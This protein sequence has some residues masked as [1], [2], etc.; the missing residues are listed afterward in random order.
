MK[1]IQRLI[2]GCLVL[3]MLFSML[4]VQVFANSDESELQAAET[5]GGTCGDDLTWEFDADSGTLT[6]SG[7]GD[8]D[9]SWFP[10][11]L[12]MKD[13]NFAPWYDIA[14]N[15]TSVVI[16]DGVT[17]VG[18]FA[19]YGCV[20]LTD[21]SIPDSVTLIS[22][23]FVGCDSLTE[24]YI[25]A[26]VTDF[27]YPSNEG[28]CTGLTRITVDADNPVY[29]SDEAGMLYNKDKTKFIGCPTGY[30]G[31]YTIA[32]GVTEIGAWAFVR[33]EGLTE[34]L[35]P[36]TVTSIG[37][38][39]FAGCSGLSELILPEGITTIASET[40]FGCALTELTIPA[41][42]NSIAPYALS[43]CD[44]LR[45]VYFKGDAPSLQFDSLVS[46]AA[47]CYYPANNT[48]WTE[49]ITDQYGGNIVWI[50]YEEEETCN[51][52]YTAEVTAPTCEEKGYTTFTCDCGDSYVDNYVDALG[53]DYK[54][55]YCTR[56]DEEDPAPAKE[57]TCGNDARWIFDEISGTLTI[58]G[59]GKMWDYDALFDGSAEPVF[60]P[61][62]GFRN[63]IRKVVV[64]EGITHIG[65][66]AFYEISKA[67]EI[68]LPQRG[69]VR[70]GE[71]A[72]KNSRLNQ[73]DLP[74]SVSEIGRSA[75]FGTA[76]TEIV[77][78]SGVTVIE[79]AMFQSADNLEEVTLPDGIKEIKYGAFWGTNLS[80]ITIPDSVTRIGANAFCNCVCLS[81]IE[82][83]EYVESLGTGAFRSCDN[84]EKI[85]FK[86]NAP[87]F[88]AADE[89]GLG[90]YNQFG[91]V[92]ATAYYPANLSTWTEGVM[93]R[94][95]GTITWIPYGEEPETH[96]HSGGK[97]TCAS[98]AIC[99]ECGENYGEKD[100]TNHTGETEI[101]N[102]KEATEF[103]DGYTG[104]T[105]CLSCGKLLEQGKVISG[106]HEHDH[107]KTVTAPTCEEKGYTTYTCKCGDSYVADEVAALG[108]DYDEGVITTK[109]GCKTEGVMTYTCLNNAAHSYAVA[110]AATG[111][112]YNNG[113]VTTAPGC[114]TTGVKTYTCQNDK[115]HIYTTTIPVI[116]HSYDEGVM[117]PAPTCTADG[118]R[119]FTCQNDKTHTKRET[120]NATGHTMG[121][122][123]EFKPS[124][125]KSEGEDR[126]YCKN[127]DCDYYESR[128]IEKLPDP[129][130]KSGTCGENLT[131]Q[132]DSE[133]VLTISGTGPMGNFDYP[134][135]PPW[136]D[137]GDDWTL[138]I[139]SVIINEGVTTVGDYAFEY[140]TE[141]ETVTL[142]DSITSIGIG[143]FGEC[144]NL[145]S[146]NIPNNTTS[147]KTGAFFFCWELEEVYIPPSV[148]NIDSGAFYGGPTKFWVDSENPY[149]SSDRFGVLYNKEQ[150]ELIQCMGIADG[151]FIPDTVKKIG[152]CAFE[153]G[154]AWGHVI[155]PE[156]VE[157]IGNGAF[158]Y[159]YGLEA[160]TIPKSVTTIGS[161]VFVAGDYVLKD[162]Y[163]NGSRSQWN[164][165]K[166]DETND[167]ELLNATIHYSVEEEDNGTVRFFR[168]ITD[169]HTLVFFGE[170]EIS[171]DL[172]HSVTEET[173][174]SF[175]DNLDSLLG[176]YVLAK[177]KVEVISAALYD[178]ILLSIEP[179]ETKTGTVTVFDGETITI[180]GTTYTVPDNLK[181]TPIVVGDTIMYHLYEGEL[182]GFNGEGSYGSGDDEEESN[183]NKSS[184]TVRYYSSWDQTSKTVSFGR[185]VQSMATVADDADASLIDALNS[186]KGSYVFVKTKKQEGKDI[187]VSMVPVQTKFGTVSSVY[188]NSIVVDGTAYAIPDEH[189]LSGISVNDY[190]LFHVY[191]EIVLNVEFL[192][193]QTGELMGWNSVTRDVHI[194]VDDAP[195][196][197]AYSF[198]L[199][200]LANDE[201]LKLL[202]NL[203]GG[204]VTIAKR[205]H[206]FKDTQG[207]IYSIFEYSPV[208]DGNFSYLSSIKIDNKEVVFNYTYHYDES[209]FQKSSYTYQHGLTQMSLRV[210]MSAGD[211]RCASGYE[212]KNGYDNLE[213]LMTD[214]NF[215]K[216][217]FHY[218]PS[219]LEKD[220]DNIGY[221]IGSKTIALED[222]EKCTLIMIGVR[223]SGYGAE[224]GG[225]FHIGESGLVSH[226][227]FQIA[228]DQVISGLETYIEENET[229]FYPRIK[230]WISGFS[231]AGATTNL[232]A[233]FLD[234]GNVNGVSP[235]D[236]YAYCFEC[237]QNTTDS[238]VTEELYKNIVSIVNPIDLVTKLAMSDWNFS[239]YG[240][241]Y[242]LPYM[243][244]NGEDYGSLNARMRKE[245]EKILS[246]Q[247]GV[248]ISVD[249]AYKEVKGQASAFDEFASFLAYM[250]ENREMYTTTYQET[251]M[252]AAAKFLPKAD[253][254][255]EMYDIISS[256]SGLVA[257]LAKEAASIHYTSILE[258]L[259][260]F[261]SMTNDF[262]CLMNAHYMELCLS[263]VD[264]LD[265]W[266]LISDGV[267]YRMVFINCPVDV[268]VYNNG[269]TLVAKIT[270]N[271]VQEIN[272]GIVARID[273]NGQ[274]IVI[275]PP[276][277][278]Y[279]L[280]LNAT[281]NGYMT[282]TV[283]EYNL[284]S[285]NTE[286]VVSYY[287]VELT[288]GDC[289]HGTIENLNESAEAKYPLTLSDGQEATATIDQSGVEV[290][291]FTVDVQV[292][293]DGSVKGGGRYLN[294]EFAKVTAVASEGSQFVGWFVDGKLVSTDAE[295][296]FAVKNDTTITAQFKSADHV[297]HTADTEWLTDSTNHWHKC[298]GCAEIMDL[299][300]HSGGTATCTKQAVCKI[301]G[302]S[303]GKLA[304]HD[305]EKGWN[306]GNEAGHWH[307]CKNCFA[308][309]LPQKHSP[310]AAATEDSAQTCTVCGYVIT[311]ALGHSC[312]PGSHWYYGTNYH[313]KECSCGEQFSMTLHSYTDDADTTCN[314]CGKV[315]EISAV[316]TPETTKP[317]E[318]TIPNPAEEN[319]IAEETTAETTVNT[320]AVEE[321]TVPAVSEDINA[322]ESTE[323]SDGIS[324]IIPAIVLVVSGSLIAL[325]M[326]L[327]KKKVI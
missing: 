109:P 190:I 160:V 57:G 233:A 164:Q 13:P 38:S 157:C 240:I 245:Y 249:T 244:Y 251:I 300:A 205:I 137:I 182:V 113:E 91:G 47:T 193:M 25:P 76:L 324:V 41:S 65:N 8:M 62:F 48:T 321:V 219:N 136:H 290:K 126:R 144:Y 143:A 270:N 318:A 253:V 138:Y 81:E 215:S 51:H 223:G 283:T 7:T 40:F 88:E 103:E 276:H 104:D 325:V 159:C 146:I 297:T 210:A 273:S 151:F 192:P 255:F 282:Y 287:D 180:D 189:I 176:T 227:G 320:E 198:T 59:T 237:P 225:N 186:L 169:D 83:P 222:G 311:P 326:F 175:L 155:I 235:Q 115:S 308:H 106:T 116:G 114:E 293:N 197:G 224:W 54:Y 194:A 127:N 149:Y 229:S 6:I 111:H 248:N 317:T 294:G 267:S 87:V 162:V 37:R 217:K 36:E 167:D 71:G 133:G 304:A 21:V 28:V 277:Q 132:L 161:N 174:K 86:G 29:S 152:D 112:N 80:E 201:T 69:L 238:S 85:T 214:L 261:F 101:R 120:I 163:Y 206:F 3:C 32:E 18:A 178:H 79:K 170:G 2:S 117:N 30:Q 284:D 296:R 11:D 16:E 50:A 24:V 271:V 84:L 64:S 257:T 299:A 70:V 147:I 95:G 72:F 34:I 236:V 310:G 78:P 191:E 31:S 52:S 10:Y 184:S 218:P 207:F 165:I 315:R 60:C 99:S 254:D 49:V 221:G 90:N 43:G 100:S 269:G 66:H 93:Q 142:P 259:L 303:Y 185:D 199:S 168:S 307:E 33:C 288:K 97:A 22:C 134:K 139:S 262:D 322:V 73:I 274:K 171:F 291:T 242:L 63:A 314:V 232:V 266:T 265:D 125:Y 141:L 179:L 67:Y 258:K 119:I 226:L 196:L 316:E 9:S 94:Y 124:T 105:Y 61:W 23:T 289:L 281:D 173:D 241:T 45:E 55:G 280:T 200:N 135:D 77:I 220:Y 278:E 181:D 75:F 246:Y 263:W 203:S 323:S 204:N 252:D 243:E 172:G 327:K 256:I 26:S 250:T 35:I 202:N 213:A 68:D 239:R 150:T 140:C 183:N 12:P 305:Y 121:E 209:W 154:G 129:I 247:N 292:A 228:A 231:R 230:V 298:T 279:T 98:A 82:I 128:N 131:W 17:S 309:T 319:P 158:S 285:T 313:W 177:T 286:R 14:E 234:E 27:R 188:R 211:I 108:H 212:S 301:C 53:H 1:A 92:T 20:N 4:P 195:D 275:L 58:S 187:L 295:Y 148:T 107:E 15:I 118:V 46:L 102:A 42:V 216:L 272:N 208:I 122:W 166:I 110:V 56:C 156:G 74:D 89:D 39:A 19:F 306:K 145:E 153:Y 268:A 130:I 312:T 123:R 44:S 264:S 302:T 96:E 5:P 260:Q